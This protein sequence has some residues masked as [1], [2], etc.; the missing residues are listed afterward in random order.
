MQ[1]VGIKVVAYDVAGNNIGGDS[2]AV[3]IPPTPSQ[4]MIVAPVINSLSTNSNYVGNQGIITMYGSGFVANMKSNIIFTG[5]GKTWEVFPNSVTPTTQTFV[6]P[7]DLTA[8][9]YKISVKGESGIMSNSVDFTVVEVPTRT[10]RMF[11]DAGSSN[12]GLTASIWDAV[13]EY[14]ENQ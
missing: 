11:N 3:S 7:A 12:A 10:R 9:S 8:G 4:P 13:R 14:F 6:M 5:N 2:V 1:T